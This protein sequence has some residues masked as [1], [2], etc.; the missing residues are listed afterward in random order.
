MVLISLFIK[1][2]CYD[3]KMCGVPAVE[4]IKLKEGFGQ[5]EKTKTPA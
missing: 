2:E 1:R 3:R 5:I 4:N